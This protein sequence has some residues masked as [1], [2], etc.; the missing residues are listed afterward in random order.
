MNLRWHY[1]KG[2][3]ADVRLKAPE[4][5]LKRPEAALKPASAHP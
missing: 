4:P 3:W 5:L 1:E 2:R